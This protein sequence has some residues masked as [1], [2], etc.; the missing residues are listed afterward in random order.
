MAFPVVLNGRTYTLADFEGT[1]YVD[2]LPDAFEDFVTHAGDIYNDTST[3]SAAI[4]TG[5]KTFTVSSGKPYQAGTPL[6]IAD[7]AAPQTNFLDCIVT[8]YSGT[9]L[10]VDVF[11]FAGSGTK[12]SW[13]INIGGAKTVDG[14]LAISQGGT[15]A[16]TAAAAATA[17]G[18]GTGDSPTFAGLTVTGMTSF[19][20][21]DIDNVGDIAV[22]SISGDA[23]ANTSITFAGSDT[24]NIAAGGSTIQSIT[25]SGID[26]TGSVTANH[27]T[28]SDSFPILKLEDSDGTNQKMEIVTSSGASFLTARNGSSHGTINLRR[29]NGTDTLRTMQVQSSGDIAIYADD[30]T[31]K[32]FYWDASTSRLGLGTLLPSHEIHIQAD[33]PQFRLEDS[34]GTNTYGDIQFNGNALSL[35]SRGGASAHGVMRFKSTNGT[36]TLNRLEI[37]S[38]GDVLF[39]DDAGAS[40]GRWD[41]S[42]KSLGI[43]TVSPA[44]ALDVHDSGDATIRIVST[45]TGISDDTILRSQISGTTASNYLYFGDADDNNSG[46]IR[47]VHSDDSMRFYAGATTERIRLYSTASIFYNGVTEIGRFH[48]NNYFGVGATAPAR[49]LHVEVSAGTTPT[50]TGIG[51]TALVQNNTSTA[52][53]A[54]YGIISGTAA[55]GSLFFGDADD[56][57]V[58]QIQYEHNNDAMTFRT[59]GSERLRIL[60]GGGI[61]FN[62]DTATANALDDYE[63]GTWTPSFVG[64]TTNPVVTYDVIQGYYTKVGRKVTCQFILRT[65]G[66]TTQGAGTLQVAGLPFSSANL[67]LI[68][69]AGSVAF[70]FNFPANNAPMTGYVNKNSTKFTLVKADSDDP[71]DGISTGVGAANLGTGASNNYVAMSFTYITA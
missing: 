52:S 55:N 40:G 33:S 39:Y 7:A 29:T 31:T 21:I 61:T 19:S 60:S 62:G 28:L 38:N 44:V 30:G 47:Y 54:G 25:T 37:L 56:A 70:A 17:L 68:Y 43:G 6:R 41:A 2:G 53:S 12:T 13:T 3:S 9:S 16:T 36:D 42:T 22:D 71:R 63:E 65:T 64:T 23:D 20:D 57:D 1:N 27:L 10:V 32:A 46:Q 8:S 34:D 15:G 51:M 45:G 48:S 50:L 24:I 66:V 11:G 67:H 58:G 35:I 59:N 69:N 49:P 14:T 4:G 5:S 18:L 26:V